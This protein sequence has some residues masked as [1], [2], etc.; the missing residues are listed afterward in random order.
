M[1]SESRIPAALI[2][3]VAEVCS[4]AET[5]ASLDGLFLE[6]GAPG[7]PPPGS[8]HV[9]ALAWLRIAS[10]S[11]EDPLC[12]VGKIIEKYI[13]TVIDPTAIDAHHQEKWRSRIQKTLADQG[14]MY[15]RGGVLAKIG[16]SPQSLTL[17]ELVKQRDVKSISIE[18]ERTL[19]SVEQSPRDAVSAASNLLESICK[20]YIEEQGLEMPAKQDLK[21][22]WSIVRRDLGIN[23]SLIQDRD[24]QEIMSG[25][26]SIV[27]GLAALRTHASSAH[28]AGKRMYRLEPRHARLAVH[29][30]HTLALF[31]LESWDKRLSSQDQ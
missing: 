23:P 8:K 7:D 29:G 30:A 15:S 12:I 26:I 14:I 11:C 21:S 5:H 1:D 13:E 19:S 27:G 17:H 3:V 24:M 6:A 20:V 2:A 16:V 4:E 25:L 10:K 9:K 28:G 22:V 18:F 31:L